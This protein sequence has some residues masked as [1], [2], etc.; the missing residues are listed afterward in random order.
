MNIAIIGVGGVGGYFGGKLSQIIGEDST[1]KL[2][3][4]ARNEHLK[5]IQKNGLILKTAGEG[6]FICKPTMVTDDFNRLPSL[7]ICLI[8]VKAY[9]LENVLENIKDKVQAHTSIIPLLNGVDIYERI[10]KVIQKGTVYPSCVYVGT[11][12]E[13]PGV[14]VQNGGSCTIIFGEDP[15]H[16]Q[17]SISHVLELFDKANIKYN[18]CQTHIE[19]IWTK[20]MFIA[21]Y[22]LVTAS[23]EKT[24]GEVYEDERLSQKVIAIMEEINQIAHA[25]GVFLPGN[26]IEDSYQK[27]CNFPYEAKTSFQRDYEKK[28]GKDEREVFGKAML[29][30]GKQ[31]NISTPVLLETYSKLSL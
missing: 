7:D 10:R 16:K 9:D 26:I 28:L 17:N 27:A 14:V 13:E 25:K 21:A 24:V 3:F 20:Y 12:I 11:H 22:G 5:N 29:D 30:M 19:E 31:Y 4:I 8:C 1:I 2:Y 6:E 23:E 18:W 15:L